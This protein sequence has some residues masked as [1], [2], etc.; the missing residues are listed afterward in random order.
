MALASYAGL[1]QYDLIGVREDLSDVVSEILLKDT[2]LL[3]RIGISGVATAV[4]HEWLEDS[5]NATTVVDN[6]A[7]DAAGTNVD[8]AVTTGQGVRTRIGTLLKDTTEGKS[9]VLL[10]TDISTDTLTITRGYGSTS[11]EA[12]SIGSTWRIIGNP[13]QSGADL[14]TDVSTV[15]SRVF[16]YCQ[17]FERGIQIAGD[18][19]AVV[20]A[21]V[22][23]ELARQSNQRLM[24]LLRELDLSLINGIIAASASSDTV[25]RTMGGLIEYINVAGGNTNS[26]SESISPDVI[27]SMYQQSYDDGGTPSVLALNQVQMRKLST[28]DADKVRVVPGPGMAGRFITQYMT[29]LGAVLDIVIDRWIPSDTVL[30]LDPTRI[31]VVPMINRAFGVEPIAKTGDA[32][33]NQIIGDYTVEVRNA[34]QAHAIHTNLVTS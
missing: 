16:N 29:D 24:E 27:N 32:F 2:N 18:S 11:P 23:D 1:A 3:S 28:F 22:P 30:L 31:A 8:I 34:T 25:Y 15:R 33:K 19:Q 4:K 13:K 21:G 9:E 6:E 20:K 17:I 12:H 7:L 5:L 14:S 26:T 10:V